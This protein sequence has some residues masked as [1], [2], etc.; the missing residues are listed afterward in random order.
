LT[1]DNFGVYLTGS[2]ATGEGDQDSDIDVA[3]VWEPAGLLDYQSLAIENSISNSRQLTGGRLDP[4][5][6]R[7]EFLSSALMAAK[8]PGLKAA[9]KLLAGSD[10]LALAVMPTLAQ[11]RAALGDRARDLIRKMHRQ[12]RLESW[13]GLPDPDRPFFGYTRRLQWYPAGIEEGT[14]EI[15]E[16]AAGMAAPI[17]AGLTNEYI[18]GKADAIRRFVTA[19]DDTWAGLVERVYRRCRINWHNQVPE[20]TDERDEL[21]QLCLSIHAFENHFLDQFGGDP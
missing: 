1:P 3:V 9:S 21:T 6:L 13:I 4:M 14:G 11:H 10:L 7:S 12:R 2:F 5:S 20:R 15:V 19:S 17:A 16:L 18:V 8:M